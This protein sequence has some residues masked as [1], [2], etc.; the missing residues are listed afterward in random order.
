MRAEAI[1]IPMLTLVFWTF[2]IVTFLAYKRFG[3]IFAGRA[4]P[5][6][7]KIGESE[8]VPDD[9]RVVAR[10][11]ANLFEMPVLFYAVCISSYVIHQI[12]TPLL[13]L[14]WCYV[15]LRIIHSLVHVTY[16]H[17]LYRFS[18]Y[19]A[20]CL[21]LLIMWIS[22]AVSLHNVSEVSRFWPFH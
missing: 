20:S 2:A 18:I 15:G 22:F 8:K 5:G 11:V 1:F 21:L 9:I 12:S 10:N 17:L 14:A 7:F 19:L 13:V 16:N 3:A 6:H 4:K